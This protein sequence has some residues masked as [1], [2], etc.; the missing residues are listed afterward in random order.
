MKYWI[1][2]EED[3]LFKD[4]ANYFIEKCLGDQGTKN[5]HW[6]TGKESKTEL[7]G[8]R[9]MINGENVKL[10]ADALSKELVHQYR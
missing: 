9:K 5:H 4:E 8:R 7:S 6:K 10:N 1:N 3:P 2:G